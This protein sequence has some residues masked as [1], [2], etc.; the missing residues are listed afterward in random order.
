[1]AGGW[2]LCR[3]GW[4]KWTQMWSEDGRPYQGCR[5]CSAVQD[6]VRGAGGTASG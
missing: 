6:Y 5:R 1:M 4:H 3:I 2:L